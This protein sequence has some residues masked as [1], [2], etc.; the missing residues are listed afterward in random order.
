EQ[1]AELVRLGLRIEELY[2][3]PM[4]I[5]WALRG[6]QVF[7]VQARPITALPEPPPAAP[8]L[9]AE[10]WPLPNP[11]AKYY[12]ASVVELLPDPVSPLFAT[13]ALPAWNAALRELM[14]S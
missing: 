3:Q 7:V 11:S 12:R 2:G 10:Q 1:V 13:L 5:E 4:D 14:Q 8:A 6:G 9:V